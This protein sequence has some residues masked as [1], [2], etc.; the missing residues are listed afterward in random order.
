MVVYD[1]HS[2]RPTIVPGCEFRP[3]PVAAGL[4]AK[5]SICIRCPGIRMHRVYVVASGLLDPAGTFI[6]PLYNPVTTVMAVF[7]F[8]PGL[9]YLPKKV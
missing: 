7:S 6:T 1:R 4:P 5:R 8:S 9:P 3:C 2:D